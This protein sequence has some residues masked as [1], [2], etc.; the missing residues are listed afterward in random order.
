MDTPL[1]AKMRRQGNK[2]GQAWPQSP[3]DPDMLQA[4]RDEPVTLT[5]IGRIPG[6]LKTAGVAQGRSRASRRCQ[7]HQPP[8]PMSHDHKVSTLPP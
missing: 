7:R 6:C 5:I 2:A 3:E 1:T 8:S 4:D